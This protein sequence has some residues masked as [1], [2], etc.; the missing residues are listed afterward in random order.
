MARA[1]KYNLDYFPHIISTGKKVSYIRKKYGN[2]GYATWFTILEELGSADFH[3]LDLRNQSDDDYSIQLMFLSERC[4]VTE[5]L[6]LQII[7][8]LVKLNGFDK[9]LWENRILWSQ[10]FYDSIQDAWRRRDKKCLTKEDLLNMFTVKTQEPRK[11]IV[12]HEKPEKPEIPEIPKKEKVEIIFPF[13]TDEFKSKW[14]VWKSFRKEQH[15]F[16]Y[17]SSITE[18]QALIT[19]SKLAEM[20]EEI[21]INIISQSINEGWKGLFKLKND[22]NE[23]SNSSTKSNSS[24]QGKGSNGFRTVGNDFVEGIFAELQSE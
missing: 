8:D 21:A 12:K 22:S 6:L 2:D 5:E 1:Q 20:N 7:N 3:Y 17:K 23:K 4:N 24:S 19:L 13:D 10:D 9:T 14:N 11:K 16:L 18:Q 15:G